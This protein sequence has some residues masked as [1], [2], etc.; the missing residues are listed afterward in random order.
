[1]KILLVAPGAMYSTLDVFNGYFNA[2]KRNPEV[3]IYTEQFHKTLAWH[4]MA[5]KLFFGKDYKQELVMKKASEDIVMTI[6]KRR[7]DWVIFVS[8]I[9]FPTTV[10]E[11]TKQLQE[12][13]KY[14][15]KTAVLFTESPY[16]EEWEKG[17]LE[18][19][20]AAFMTD[21]GIIED[22]RKINPNTHYLRHAYDSSIHYRSSQPPTH[23]LFMVATGFPERQRLLESVDW[24]G[25]DLQ[26]YGN[27]MYLKPDSPLFPY[28]KGEN[29]PNAET[30]N[31]YRDSKIALNIF[32]TV[33]WPDAQPKFIEPSKAK[34]LSPRC[35]EALACGSLLL[36]DW[37]EELDTLPADSCVLWGSAEELKDKVDYYLHHEEERRRI[38][39]AGYNAIQ[40]NTFDARAIELLEHLKEN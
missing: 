17:I 30:A 2:F 15:F 22:Y 23:D 29:L 36:T 20:D 27:W 25:I 3:Q 24:T 6:F 1:M 37:R 28:W 34:S 9:A 33:E 16:C 4:D 18:R 19:V 14:K 11:Y 12:E 35:Y 40:G 5:A 32:R 39:E 7:P 26:L 8:G 38:A 31:R 21:K 10:W 13:W